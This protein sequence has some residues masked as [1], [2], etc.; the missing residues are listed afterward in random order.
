LK[1]RP[2]QRIR[3]HADFQD[4]YEHGSRI[5]GRYYTLFT[6][7][8]GLDIGRL[9]IA[10]TKRLGGAVIRNRAKRLIREVF[11]RN[12][13]A[14]GFDIVVVPRREFL[15]TSLTA[16]ETDYRASVTRRIL[17]SR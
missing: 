4:V 13:I 5:S 14:P 15:A 2:E 7:P 16:L 1:F 3:R 11:R 17:K 6:K 12:D 10:A 9:G 8:N